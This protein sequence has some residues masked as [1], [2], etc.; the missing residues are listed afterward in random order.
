VPQSLIEKTSFLFFRR[1]WLSQDRL[2][3][4]AGTLRQSFTSYVSNSLIRIA[5][6]FL[7]LSA[8]LA[9]HL[10]AADAVGHD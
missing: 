3:Y 5:K 8:T 4:K 7:Q 1:D 2:G 10:I 6:S 9:R